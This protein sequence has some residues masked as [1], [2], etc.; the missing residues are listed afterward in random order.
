[1]HRM[2]PSLLSARG[3][4][5]TEVVVKHE[6]RKFGHSK[7]GLGRALRSFFD[8]FTV[9]F[10][11]KYYDRPAHLF[12]PL[13]LLFMF[14]GGMVFSIGLY[15]NFLLGQGKL[16]IMIGPAII[17]TGLVVLCIGLL[18]ELLVYSFIRDGKFPPPEAESIGL[19]K[20]VGT[21]I[22]NSHNTT[23]PNS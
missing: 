12:G 6:K 4:K 2:I 19:G 18:A 8:L 5:I 23:N 7:F 9:L 22:A 13:A 11:R 21:Q 3:F 10:L 16:L 15:K 17:V 20:Q 1:M 14:G